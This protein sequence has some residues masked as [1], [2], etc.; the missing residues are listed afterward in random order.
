MQMP[1][2][3]NYAPNKIIEGQP[4]NSMMLDEN[5]GMGRKIDWNQVLMSAIVK[6]TSVS[7]DEQ[8][9][10][11]SIE[12]LESLMIAEVAKEDPMNP[13]S[14]WAQKEKKW[15]ELQEQFGKVGEGEARH[16]F[17]TFRFRELLLRLDKRV[18]HEVVSVL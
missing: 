2:Y 15:K 8:K 16:L 4:D 1:Y 6:I 10:Q 9:Y 14:Y 7:D 18:P 3:N 13:K 5:S 11:Q 17:N 12:H